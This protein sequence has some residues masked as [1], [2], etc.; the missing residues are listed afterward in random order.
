LNTEATTPVLVE[1]QEFA[2]FLSIRPV[3]PCV[4]W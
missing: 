4:L 1:G 2:E 3:T